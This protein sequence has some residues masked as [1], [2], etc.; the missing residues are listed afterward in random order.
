MSLAVLSGGLRPQAA[1]ATARRGLRPERVAGCGL[2]PSAPAVMVRV[3]AAP[4]RI[5][6]LPARP[7]C[8]PMLRRARRARPAVARGERPTL[9]PEVRR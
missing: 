7:A 8:P 4:G 9:P 6:P 5:R 2:L 1:T 3:G